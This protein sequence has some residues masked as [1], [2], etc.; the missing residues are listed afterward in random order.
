M[1]EARPRRAR[2]QPVH[3][4]HFIGG[5]WRGTADHVR[6]NPARPG[7]VVSIAPDGDAHDVRD[8]VEAAVDAL[9]GWRRVP[10]P[11]R[12]AFLARTAELLE[13][14]SAEL[15]E[16]I[17][18]EEG[19]TINEARGEVERSVELLRFFAGAG[20][21]LTGEVLP[22][23][24]EGVTIQTRRVP[25]GVIGLITP[26]NFPLA[27]PVWKLA[28]A[29]VC[30][31]TVVIK[32]AELTPAPVHVLMQCLQEAELPSGVV[33]AVY[34][35]GTVAGAALVADARVAAISFTGSVDVGRAVQQ[36][37]SARMARAQLEM[38]GKNALVVLDDADPRHAAELAALGAFGLTGQAC[39]ATSRLICTPA[40]HDAVID[41]L[42]SL[43]PAWSPGDGLHPS[44]RMGPAVDARQLERN[45]D[46]LALAEQE[47][48]RMI[49]GGA[50]DGLLFPP[51]VLVDVHPSMRTAREEAFAPILS[52]LCA[53]DLDDAIR[54]V[55]DSPF[56]LAAGIAT[57]SLDAAL[58]F[59]E[60]CDVGT[61]K[62]NQPT[63]G[64]EPNAPFGGVK[65]SSNGGHREQGDAALEFYSG[66]R[67]VYLSA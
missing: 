67:T 55:N 40:I 10:A 65:L 29:L 62:V 39:T 53:E 33:N 49:G 54:I 37:A 3:V 41:A 16:L 5:A 1:P 7:E 60:D 66:T 13:G 24:V 47:G 44:T 6:E 4:R 58:R 63:T 61:V 64:N 2:D 12:G 22:A 9:D 20:W 51:A 50:P 52:V 23:G 43:L 56:G 28:P 46:H 17:C 8:A 21:R 57:A 30:G 48:A 14:R 15:S 31:N 32:P 42:V 34:G 45:V 27:I 11:R 26:W 19:K 59:A 38:G 36:A 35:P 18:R 25:V